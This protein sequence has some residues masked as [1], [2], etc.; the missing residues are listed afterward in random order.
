MKPTTA[1]LL[2]HFHIFFHFL[3][4]FLLDIFFIYISNAIQKVPYTL[5]PPLLP[6]PLTS[7]SWPWQS[8]QDQGVPVMAH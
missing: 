1:L 3:K 5:P 4:K 7:T 6:Y 2:F 8:L